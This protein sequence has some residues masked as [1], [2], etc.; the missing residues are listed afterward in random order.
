MIVASCNRFI[1]FVGSSSPPRSVKFEYKS[2]RSVLISWEKPTKTN[3]QLTSY[4]IFYS[5]DKST[6]DSEWQREI[7]SLGVFGSKEE[8]M[9]RTLTGIKENTT[10][11]LKI[12]A[13]NQGGYGPF[14]K[15]VTVKP[16]ISVPRVSPNVSYT[17][18]SPRLVELSWACP[19]I[20]NAVVKRFTILITNN[21]NDPEDSWNIQIVGIAS[22]KRCPNV[23][24]KTIAVNQHMV[25]FIKVRAEYDDQTPGKWS[26]IVEIS[27]GE[28]AK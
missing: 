5:Y 10:F 1:S 8:K 19:R 18:L 14:C 6:P 28:Q 12:R 15:T 26:N 22:S 27:T 20:Y 3:G 25:Y 7:I 17:I 4:E 9:L 13:E 16:P 21:K 23:V 2:R 24:T 11:Y